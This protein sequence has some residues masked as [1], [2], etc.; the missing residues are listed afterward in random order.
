MLIGEF[1][2]YNID[3]LKISKKIKRNIINSSVSCSKIFCVN[4]INSVCNI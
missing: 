3:Y 1:S 4:F 2:I